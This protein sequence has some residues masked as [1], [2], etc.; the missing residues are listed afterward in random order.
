MM[1]IDNKRSCAGAKVWAWVQKKT[2][3]GHSVDVGAEE[4]T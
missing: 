3:N 1:K 2:H 4:D